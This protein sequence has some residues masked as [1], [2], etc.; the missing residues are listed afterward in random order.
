MFRTASEF[1]VPIAFGPQ[2]CALRPAT[3]RRGTLAGFLSA[4]ISNLATPRTGIQIT[5]GEDMGANLS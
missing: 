1:D 4:R 5:P 3:G 2:R